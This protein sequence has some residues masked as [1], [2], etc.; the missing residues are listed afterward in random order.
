M[1]QTWIE[2]EDVMASAGETQASQAGLEALAVQVD[3]ARCQL[4]EEIKVSARQARQ[5]FD[6]LWT[7]LSNPPPDASLPLLADLVAHLRGTPA[8]RSWWG[9]LCMPAAAVVVAGMLGI[10]SGWWLFTPSRNAQLW[11]RLGE[12]VD[13]VMVEHNVNLPVINGVYTQL[14]IATPTARKGKR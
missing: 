2:S 3:D 11:A 1:A 9:R 8:Q 6:Q 10:G 5:D 7:F 14:G 4:L 12:R 13:A